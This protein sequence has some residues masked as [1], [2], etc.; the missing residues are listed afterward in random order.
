MGLEAW[1]SM[2]IWSPPHRSAEAQA[3][4]EGALDRAHSSPGRC[5]LGREGEGTGSFPYSGS[6]PQ[7]W[8]LSTSS[9]TAVAQSQNKA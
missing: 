5:H 3:G 1:G 4:A 2:G 8:N 6:Q 9:L 7:R